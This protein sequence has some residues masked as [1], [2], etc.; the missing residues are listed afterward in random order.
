MA[1]DRVDLYWRGDE[2]LAAVQPVSARPVNLS[3]HARRLTWKRY[4]TRQELTQ[5]VQTRYPG[6]PFRGFEVLSRGVSGRIG[7]LKLLGGDGEDL[8]V[9]AWRCAGPSIS[10]TPS[11]TSNP[12]GTIPP[13]RAGRSP[14]VAGATG[15]ACARPEPTAWRPGH[16]LPRHSRTLLLGRGFG[17]IGEHTVAPLGLE[18]LGP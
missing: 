14:A 3:R 7:Q 5:S 17:S 10:T 6:F 11:S 2:I 1:G 13:L 18:D 16:R 15:W 8:L 9:E 12:G 4:K